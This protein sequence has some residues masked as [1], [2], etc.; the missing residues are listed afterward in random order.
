MAHIPATILSGYLGAGKTTAINALL[1]D[2]Q[3][4]RLAVLV[5]D[6]GAVNIDADLIETQDDQTISL[7]NG[8][9]CCSIAD[10]LGAALTAQTQRGDPPDHLV[11]EA[12][13]VSHPD[14]IAIHVGGW[15]GI[16]M[17]KVVTLVD[18]LTVHTRI[19]DKYVGSLV[20]KQISAAD[21][22]LINKCDLIEKAQVSR[23]RD[24]LG[25]LNT[26]APIETCIDGQVAP[27]LF[28]SRSDRSRDTHTLHG[29]DLNLQSTVWHLKPDETVD[30]DALIL[31]LSG[32]PTW[33][34]RVKGFVRDHKT[35]ATYLLQ[36]TGNQVTK[37]VQ[38]KKR[39]SQLVIFS[40]DP[41]YDPQK[42]VQELKDA[43]A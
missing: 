8:C 3:G 13:G 9:V 35:G 24:W 1:R 11:V 12:S 23:L 29:H 42:V 43:L 17:C 40:A 30:L 18:P 39:P 20:R 15:P 36:K 4:L 7:K 32:L 38:K 41:N 2:T 6:F 27:A 25:G 14:R 21:L 34:H 33:I 10:D 31:A 5:N 28:F 16:E 26:D 37:T 22:L 19:Q